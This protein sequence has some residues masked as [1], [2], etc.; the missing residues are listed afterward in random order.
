M[1]LMDALY[2]RRSV[3]AY[4]GEPVSRDTLNTLLQAAVQAPTGMNMQ[5]WAFGVI[6]GVA[7]LKDYSDRTKAYILDHIDQFPG[8]ERYRDFFD[9]PDSNIFY[10]APAL[11]IVCA[12]PN[13]VTPE[14]D[15]TMAA[16]NIMLAA[17]DMGLGTCWIGFFGFLLNQPEVKRELGIPETYRAVAPIVIGHPLGEVPPVE[18]AAPNVLFWQE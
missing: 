4:T 16:Q 6:E 8:L 18:K 13:G 14:N 11:I 12:T 9:N 15:C 2:A 3:R 1:N 7:R 17:C 5:P 10:G